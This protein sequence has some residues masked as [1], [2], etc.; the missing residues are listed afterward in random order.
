VWFL[1][2]HVILPDEIGDECEE[3]NRLDELL[4]VQPRERLK[5]ARIFVLKKVY[6]YCCQFIN[7]VN[8]AFGLTLVA[9]DCSVRE[10]TV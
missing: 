2:K 5:G 3:G 9:V 8:K 4:I 6:D 1:D 7:K 10:V